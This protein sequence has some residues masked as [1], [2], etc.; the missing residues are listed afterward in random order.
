MTARVSFCHGPSFSRHVKDFRRRLA[1]PSK[2][3]FCPP[4]SILV[5]RGLPS[6]TIFGTDVTDFG[7]GNPPVCARSYLLIRD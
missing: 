6:G 1:T 4:V 7:T 3:A 2:R 5:A